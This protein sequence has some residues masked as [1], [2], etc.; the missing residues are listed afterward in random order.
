MLEYK[1][2]ILIIQSYV[3]SQLIVSK[4]DRI[5]MDIVLDKLMK[6]TK[7]HDK[8]S[9]SF[10]SAMKDILSMFTSFVEILNINYHLQ[11]QDEKDRE[12]V[13]LMGVSQNTNTI[14][15]RRNS[16]LPPISLDKNWLSWSGRVSMILKAFKVACLSYAP[17]TVSYKG[18]K[19]TRDNLLDWVN[20]AIN[21]LK[22]RLADENTLKYDLQN[23][24]LMR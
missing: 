21:T 18:H 1:E 7:F 19:L 12:S 24:I 8:V 11:S 2:S 20:L 13:A 5:D 14:D 10:T 9:A 23:F 6:K 16:E 4:R 3:D 15:Y 17:S 22:T